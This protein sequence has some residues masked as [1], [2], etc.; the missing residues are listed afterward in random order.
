VIETTVK[1]E[2][3]KKDEGKRE[4][5]NVIEMFFSHGFSEPQSF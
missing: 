5:R 1:E 2:Q 4:R 3:E